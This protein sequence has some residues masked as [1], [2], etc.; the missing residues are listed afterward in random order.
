MRYSD[1][2]M[3]Q[4]QPEAQDPDSPQGGANR[5]AR[6]NKEGRMLQSSDKSYEVK[7]TSPA[8]NPNSYIP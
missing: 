2:P 4:A 6:G 5:A 3:G 7:S 1:W 8:S